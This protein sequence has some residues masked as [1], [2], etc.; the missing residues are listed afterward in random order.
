MTINLTLAEATAIYKALEQK[1][2]QMRPEPD[3]Y[4]QQQVAFLQNIEQKIEDAILAQ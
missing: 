3:G 4:V 1:I 2:A